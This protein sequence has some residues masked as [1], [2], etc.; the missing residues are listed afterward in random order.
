MS[1]DPT[2][3]PE[4]SCSPSCPAWKTPKHI[5]TQQELTKCKTMTVEE[6]LPSSAARIGL[7]KDR[8]AQLHQLLDYLQSLG[9]P[10][11]SDTWALWT[12]LRIRRLE[13]ESAATKRALRA[14]NNKELPD[15]ERM[16]VEFDH[17]REMHA[18]S[19]P[20]METSCDW[21]GWPN[22]RLIGGGQAACEDCLP[23]QKVGD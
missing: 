18:K 16:K 10:M 4:V 3:Q 22:A 17:A 8:D 23:T 20:P 7:L 1:K 13:A 12:L 5:H 14:L 19:L 6:A 2:P 15:L 11:G 21:C 9:I